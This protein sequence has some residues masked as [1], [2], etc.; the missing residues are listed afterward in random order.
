MAD[1][2]LKWEGEKRFAE[3]RDEVLK[4][5][6]RAGDRV[7]AYARERMSRRQPL[8]HIKAKLSRGL[9]P[10]APG[11]YPKIVTGHLWMNVVKKPARL[12][13]TNTWEVQWGTNVP[14][15]R[16]LEYGTRRMGA[17]PWMKMAIRETIPLVDF[18]LQ[19]AGGLSK[20]SGE[21]KR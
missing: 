11:E 21:G 19:G 13:G 6:D 10:S 14:Y 12:V 20:L 5:L 1:V 16:H 4:R 3:I 18:T 17:R 2:V 8:Q 7:V 9:A 15:G